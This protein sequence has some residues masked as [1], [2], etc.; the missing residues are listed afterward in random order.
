MTVRLLP[1]AIDDIE[2]A[3]T[4]LFE[5]SPSAAERMRNEVTRALE[6][7]EAL[8]LGRVARLSDGREARRWPMGTMIIYY[9]R[10]GEVLEVLRVF[11][12]RREPIER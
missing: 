4:W 12:A 9:R 7:L 2:A 10:R 3:Y 5:R 1:E 6:L 8:D 11:D